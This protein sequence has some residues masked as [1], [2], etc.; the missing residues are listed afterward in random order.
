MGLPGEITLI[1]PDDWHLHV[2]DGEMLRAVVPYTASQFARAIIMPNLLPPVTTPEEARAYQ[3]RILDAV[4]PG[5]DFEP[6]MVAYL[7]DDT[8]PEDIFRGHREGVFTA[9]KLYPSGATTN[10]ASGV[11]DIAKVRAVLDCMQDIG[12]PLLVH[13]EVTDTDIDIF[14]RETVF[15]ERT[16]APLVETFP[17]LKVVLEHVTT[18]QAVEFVFSA[19]ENVGATITV[20]HLM[21]NRNALFQGGMRPH[22]YCLPV[23]K[24]EGHRLALRRAATSGS[25]KFFLGTDSAPHPQSAKEADCG[26]AGIFSAP[27]ALELYAQVFAEEQRLDNLEKFASINGPAFYGLPVNKGKITLIR[28][29]TETPKVIRTSDGTK[30]IPFL[31]GETLPYRVQSG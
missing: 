13:G 17:R 3:Q 29:N 5:I 4:P 25:Q 11:S 10:S 1:R 7:T 6:L 21:I 28:E 12:L 9:V 15:I 24:R 2:R 23:A 31:A 19:S 18:E 22:M 16:L 14:D 30:V 27:T 26:C 8:T 20:H